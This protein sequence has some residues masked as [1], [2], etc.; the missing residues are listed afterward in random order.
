MYA[1]ISSSEVRLPP[2]TL[3][4]RRYYKLVAYVNTYKSAV[5]SKEYVFFASCAPNVGQCD[6]TPTSGMKHPLRSHHRHFHGRPQA[7]A[8]GCT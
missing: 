2:S 3:I 6:V 7:G 8:R 5:G 4:N 1:G